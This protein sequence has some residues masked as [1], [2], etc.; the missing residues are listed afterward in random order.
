MEDV[1][2]LVKNIEG[3]Y[4]SNTVLAV[5]KDFERVL[6]ELDIYVYDNWEDGELLAGSR[7]RKT[8]GNLCIYVALK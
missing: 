4:E 3:I 7:N 1:Y 8:L 5:P 2:D 6:D